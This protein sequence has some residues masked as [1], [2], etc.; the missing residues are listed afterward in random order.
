MK[1]ARRGLALL[2]LLAFV[3]YAG[4]E[5]APGPSVKVTLASAAAAGRPQ[6]PP[7][8]TPDAV[9]QA[10]REY[11]G[12]PYVH[13]GDGR[14]GLDCSGLVYRVFRD[15]TGA[16]LPRGVVGLFNSGTPAKPLLHIGDL[17]FFDTFDRGRPTVASHVGIYT[18]NGRFVH[19]ASQGPR[20][21]VIVSTLDSS[22]YRDRYL[23]ARRV[24]AWRAPVLDVTVTDDHK[25]IVQTDPFPSGEPVTVRVFNGMTG[26]GPLDLVVQKDGAQVLARRIVPGAEK[27]SQVE[28]TPD[29]GIWTV[30]VARIFKGRELQNVTFTVRE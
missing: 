25:T 10:A 18:G 27:P 7:L 20:T 6:M 2:S 11:L 12:V 21:G 1:A 16:E 22:Y 19:A 17:V 4:A 30:R 29:V 13:G 23:G 26:G 9:V 28:L 3:A 24:I 15:M 8:S 14:S 5:T